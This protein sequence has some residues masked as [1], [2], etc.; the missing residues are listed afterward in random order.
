MWGEGLAKAMGE[1]GAAVLGGAER[2]WHKRHK[3]S[4]RKLYDGGERGSG[5]V[6]GG[7]ERERRESAGKQIF[8]CGGGRLGNWIGTV[9]LVGGCMPLP[10]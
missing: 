3:F 10:R 8:G 9:A 6:E 2:R 7:R 4:K 5:K 1:D